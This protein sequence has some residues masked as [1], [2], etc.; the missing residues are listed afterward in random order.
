[1]VPPDSAANPSHS[2]LYWVRRLV[3][4]EPVEVRAV[5]WSLVYFF[6]LL[7][8]WYIVR[9]LREDMAVQ[10]GVDNL[11]WMFT[12]TFVA[13]LAIVPLFGWISSRYSRRKFVPF[14]YAA[15]GVVSLVFFVLFNTELARVPLAIAFYIFASVYNLFIISVFWSFMA[16]I[17]N[18]RQAAR[19]FGFIA[20]GGT[21]GAITGPLIAATLAQPLGATN[22][23]PISVA[24]LVLS[25]I[26]VRKL[27]RW[28]ASEN[29]RSQQEPVPGDETGRRDDNSQPLG[30]GIFAGVRLIASSPYL[31]GI[32]LLILLLTSMA[33]VLYFHQTQIMGERFTDSDTRTAVFGWIDLA[34]NALTLVTQ[35]FLTSRI[36]NRTGIAITLALIPAALALG[37]LVLGVFP[38]FSVFVVIQVLRRAGNYALM[39]PAREML[40]TVLSK[41]EKYKAKNFVDTAVYR[42]G[43][44]ISAWL[45]AGLRAAGLG[46]SAVAFLAAPVAAVWAW[47]ALRLGREQTRLAAATG[48]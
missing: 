16:D 29:E 26:A 28:G 3:S 18:S 27:G 43:D 1:M 40:Y 39:R 11:Q 36:V 32:C 4:I 22:L 48:R 34:V 20:A 8:S 44:A 38:V 14:A 15:V 46:L 9:A 41:E 42:G 33:T 6:S 45:I 23:L 24:F 31:L 30:G 21:A 17:F 25:I 2:I 35:V 13:T 12:G 7:C 37:F 10:G 47:I 5:T 19:L